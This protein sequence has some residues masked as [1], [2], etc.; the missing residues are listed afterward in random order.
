M[1]LERGPI[2]LCRPG[3]GTCQTRQEDVGRV[4]DGPVMV[5]RAGY[6]CDL[7][8]WKEQQGDP[9]RRILPGWPYAGLKTHTDTEAQDPRAEV[10][11]AHV[12]VARQDVALPVE[13]D[14]TVQ[15]V[16][17]VGYQGHLEAL[18]SHVLLP[19]RSRFPDIVEAER[20]DLRRHE[21][22]LGP[23][24]AECGA[25]DDWQGI[26]LAGRTD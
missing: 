5:A 11:R 8:V 14:V 24:E 1:V 12:A 19:R 9:L 25:F 23:V 26:P 16:E 18:Q 4:P 20:V 13:G 21:H 7:E 22:A 6:V 2:L 17:Q 3:I 15:H 10:L